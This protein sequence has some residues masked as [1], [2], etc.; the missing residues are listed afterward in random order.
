[1]RAAH[2]RRVANMPAFPSG[3]AGTCR[4]PLQCHSYGDYSAI[5]HNS[6]LVLGDS[7]SCWEAFSRR[8]DRL[9]GVGVRGRRCTLAGGLRPAASSRSRGPGVLGLRKYPNGCSSLT[10]FAKLLSKLPTCASHK[11]L[12]PTSRPAFVKTTR[13]SRGPSL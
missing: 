10:G 13:E 8:P 5:T 2:V 6:G 7:A 9:S 4:S 12:D 3:D 11:K 1:M